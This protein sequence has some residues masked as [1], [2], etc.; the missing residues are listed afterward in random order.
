MN[1]HAL[2]VGIA[3]GMALSIA[4]GAELVPWWIANFAFTCLAAALG[5]YI[6]FKIIEKWDSQ[7]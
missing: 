4:A 3:L 2:T 5:G 7:R 6:G 1:A